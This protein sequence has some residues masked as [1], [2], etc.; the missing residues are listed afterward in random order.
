MSGPDGVGL[1][2][3]VNV[4]GFGHAKGLFAGLRFADDTGPQAVAS[5]KRVDEKVRAT[6]PDNIF[7]RVG[8]VGHEARFALGAEARDVEIADPPHERRLRFGIA[9]VVI[10][11]EL[12]HG[13]DGVVG[14]NVGVDDSVAKAFRGFFFQERGVS[15]D[16][17][18]DG[19]IADGV[20]ADVVAGI[21]KKFN[22]FAIHGR[23]DVGI[24]GV[25]AVVLSVFVPGFVDPGGAAA[26]AA[27]HEKFYAAGEEHAVAE[28][29][30][31]LGMLL[32]FG[33]GGAGGFERATAAD[34]PENTDGG[35]VLV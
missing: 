17:R 18:V 24:A 29:C 10:A 11:L 34:K 35:F 19:A 28:R 31:R 15:V 6:G 32:K 20:R 21:V 30:W 8:L 33:E 4:D 13:V 5:G 12:G 2:S 26:A 3:G 9:G 16:D 14:G 7:L 23:I 25:G 27:V 22:H 1:E